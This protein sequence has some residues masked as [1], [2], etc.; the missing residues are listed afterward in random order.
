MLVEDLWRAPC[1]VR[2]IENRRPSRFQHSEDSSSFHRDTRYRPP[3]RKPAGD[4]IAAQAAAVLKRFAKEPVAGES[5]P[6]GGRLAL[7]FAV[8]VGADGGSPSEAA[9]ALA[10][11]SNAELDRTCES[12]AILATTISFWLLRRSSPH[13]QRPMAKGNAP[14]SAERHQT[15]RW[16]APS[17]PDGV[18]PSFS[19]STQ[20]TKNEA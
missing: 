8:A 6:A 19:F 3:L 18:R 11:S 5:G 12:A 9:L 14:E 15:K 10:D 16:V 4:V 17:A 2:Q 1:P 7:R 13:P 20:E